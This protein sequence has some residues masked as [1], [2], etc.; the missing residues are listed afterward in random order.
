[1]RTSIRWMLGTGAAALVGLVPLAASTQE[2]AQAR[3]PSGVWLTTPYPELAI[4]PGE[5]EQVPITLRNSNLPPQRASIEVS[6]IPK[7]WDWT[8]KG[9]SHEVTAAMVAPDST[10]RLTLELTPPAEAGTA[11]KHEIEVRAAIGDRKIVLPL[12]VSLSKTARAG[13][14]TLEPELP[15]LRGTPRTTFTYRVEVKNEGAEDG[16]FNLAAQVPEGFNTRFKRG[17]GAEEIT[18]VPI[19][20]GATENVTL[21][22][23]PSHTVAAGRYPVTMEVSGGGLAATTKLSLEVTGTPDVSLAGPQERLSG[24]AVA[25]SEATFTFTVANQGSAPATGVDMAAT[26]PQG[27]KVAFEPERIDTIPPNGASEVDVSIT[28]SERAI[29]GDY[30]VTVRASGKDVSEQAQFRVGVQTSTVW[31]AVGL[32]VI[33]AAVLVLGLGIMR[34]GRR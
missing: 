17:Y 3:E 31:G 12:L 5:T 23:E 26:P 10:E 14:L 2:T 16:L 33:V 22:V 1:M 30:M 13:G 11:G 8:L 7:D 15:A 4:R 20:A 6:G 28:P 24:E 19:S 32:G 34:Y 25:G 29:A 21:E 27:W 18:G 9:G